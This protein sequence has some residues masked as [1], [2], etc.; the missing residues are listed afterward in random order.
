MTVTKNFEIDRAF[1][2]IREGLVHYRQCAELE[3]G[4][5]P[6][7]LLHAS[8][9]SARTLEPLL[10]QLRAHGATQRLIAPD[11]LGNGD[12]AAPQPEV[13]EIAYFA[14]SVLRVLDRLQLERVDLYGS[15]TGARIATELAAIAPD[16]VRKVVFDGITEYD[17]ELKEQIL[18]R[19]APPIEPDEYGRH[20][21]WVFNF[22]RDQALHF[23]YF[24]RDPAHRVQ[25][26]MPSATELHEKTLDVLKA[27]QTYQKSYLAAFRYEARKRLPLVKAPA[28][29]LA[30][31]NEAPHLRAAAAE[32]AALTPASQVRETVGGNAGKAAAIVE[33]LKS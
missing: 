13:P 15:H 12:S 27:M 19:F 9:G 24:M 21:I 17:R 2:R 32:M 29:F 16:R 11:T 1:V 10:A 3:A 5:P 22:V 23:P 20:L 26:P 33:F 4:L 8:P 28:L 6:L 14:Q 30:A 18:E 7:Y 31:D 25:K